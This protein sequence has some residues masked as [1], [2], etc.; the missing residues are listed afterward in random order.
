MKATK[1]LVNIH[2]HS[3]VG[4][5]KNLSSVLHTANMQ[6]VVGLNAEVARNHSCYHVL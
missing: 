5:N 6:V 2:E 1:R 3:P 4:A